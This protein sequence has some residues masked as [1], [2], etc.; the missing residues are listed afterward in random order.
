MLLATGMKPTRKPPPAHLFIVTNHP[1]LQRALEGTPFHGQ[2]GRRWLFAEMLGRVEG[3][4]AMRS[5]GLQATRAKGCWSRSRS[6]RLR[7]RS[8]RGL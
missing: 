3:V 2:I 5:N 7:P 8:S 1:D 4:S 6:C